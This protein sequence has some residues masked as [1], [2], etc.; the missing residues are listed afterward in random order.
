MCGHHILGCPDQKT[1]FCTGDALMMVA[2]AWYPLIGI[3][4]C[5][6]SIEIQNECPH[7]CISFLSETKN[8]F[9]RILVILCFHNQPN[10][11]EILKNA[12][13]GRFQW[14]YGSTY[15][16][17]RRVRGACPASCLV[18]WRVRGACC[19]ARQVP[20]PYGPYGH[21]LLSCRSP[22]RPCELSN[23][24]LL[25][26]QPPGQ[27]PETQSFGLCALA[28]ELCFFGLMCSVFALGFQIGI[29]G[30]LG[31]VCFWPLHPPMAGFPLFWLR[32]SGVGPLGRGYC[33]G[34]GPYDSVFWVSWCFVVHL[35]LVSF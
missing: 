29:F 21:G 27:P 35:C 10:S 23:N 25:C 24:G 17:P 31:W 16:W 19:A 3:L 15:M 14:G 4:Y 34:P 12:C 32:P 13:H 9:K 2:V 28:P 1:K 20:G 5:R 11:K 6:F 30:F 7:I 33:H 22:G 26:C 8:R 18:S